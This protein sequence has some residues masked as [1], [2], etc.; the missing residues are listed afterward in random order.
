M[1]IAEAPRHFLLVNLVALIAAGVMIVLVR[2]PRSAAIQRLAIVLLLAL[3]FLPLVLG[4]EI[5]GIARWIPIGPFQLHAGMLAIPA[6]AVLAAREPNF[7]EPILLTATFAA[8]IQ[9]DAASA[10]AIMGA[11]IGHYFA[12]P[13]WRSAVVA[14]LAFAVS[15]IAAVHGELPAQPFVERVLADAARD[16]PFAALALL[17]AWL[18]GFF[19]ILKASPLAQTERFTLAGS[20]FGFGVMG[21]ISNYPSPLIG[22]GASPILG[23]GLA[24]AMVRRV[25]I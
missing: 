11:S 9:P 16:M 20:L 3:L 23:Y 14:I 10:F 19:V 6:L 24:L 13:H 7:V 25:R 21:M 5:N 15:L 8:L 1:A 18:I 17:V 12:L 2:G 4:P 22:Y